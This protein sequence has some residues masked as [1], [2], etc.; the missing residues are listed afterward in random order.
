MSLAAVY[1]FTTYISSKL[2]QKYPKIEYFE[3]LPS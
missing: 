2:L 1:N 3:E